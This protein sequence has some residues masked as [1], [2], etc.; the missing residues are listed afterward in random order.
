MGWQVACGVD[1]QIQKEGS[2][3]GAASRTG[4]GI[5]GTGKAEGE[6]DRRR[7]SAAGSYARDVIDTAEIFSSAGGRVHKG[8]KCDTYNSR[9]RNLNVKYCKSR[10]SNQ[11]LTWLKLKLFE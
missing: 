6:Q 10:W 4:R 9:K 7:T 11:W 5:Q 2:L 8:E 3:W 1:T